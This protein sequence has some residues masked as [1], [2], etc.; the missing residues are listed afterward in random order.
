MTGGDYPGG[1]SIRVK[2][3]TGML[4]VSLD[5]TGQ[6]W[7]EEMLDGPILAPVQNLAMI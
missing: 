3:R 7:R 6:S 5:A 4:W 2:M 1:E